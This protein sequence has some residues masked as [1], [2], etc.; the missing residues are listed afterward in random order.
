MLDITSR[1]RAAAFVDLA[2]DPLPSLYVTSEPVRIDGLPSFNRFFRNAGGTGFVPVPEFGLDVSSGG[3][4]AVAANLDADADEE[5]IVCTTDASSGGGMGTRL[6]DFDGTR[7]VDRTSAL[8]IQP[9]SALDM[10][11]ADFDG[12]SLPDLAQL[13]ANRLRVSLGSP[14]GPVRLT[15]FFRT[16]EP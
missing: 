7:F 6:Y 5:L 13:R 8:G 16:D 3:V 1:G 14:T 15:A 4:C 12:D 9:F 10:E 11:V 2:A